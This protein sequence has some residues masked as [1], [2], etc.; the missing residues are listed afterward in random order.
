MTAAEL[1]ERLKQVK[2]P[3]FSRDIV[4]FGIVKDIEID[5]RRA[6]VRL[7]IVTRNEEVADQI[8][9]DVEDCLAS[10]EGIPEPDIIVEKPEPEPQ[11]PAA[12]GAAAREVG[13]GPQRVAGISK[14]VA[15]ASGKGGVGKSTV[16]ANL[17]VALAAAGHRT[18]LLDA[19]IYGPSIP[20]L[21]GVP[22]D[23]R[24]QSDEDGRLI[25]IE[26]FGVRVVSMGFFVSEGAPL[27]W[28]GPMLTKALSQ[29]L[30][31]VRWGDLDYLVIDLPPGTGDV[32]MT[33]TMQFALD[34]GVI[35]TTPQDVALADV[36]RGAKM[37]EQ[38]EVKVVGVVENMSHHICPSCG[39][40]AHIFGE[41]GGRRIAEKFDLPFLGGIPLVGTIRRHGDEGKPIVADEPEGEVAAAFR[42]IG[43]RLALELP[44]KEVGHA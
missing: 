1:K 42:N 7:A 43:E 20:T 4:S 36:E 22:A 18:G 5:E 2:Y 12:P 31:D 39:N 17:A 37:F 16:A 13:R 3:G 10:I 41:G 8:V 14:I 19:D 25:P 28:R 23:E 44:A 9:K 38:A 33:L 40:T 29:F 24:V 11:A 35:V 21:F 27:I 30:Q 6:Q 26:R 32:Q 15:V 34:G